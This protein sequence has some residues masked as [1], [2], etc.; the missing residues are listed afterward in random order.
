L[1]GNGHTEA[2]CRI[3]TKDEASSR[4]DTKDKSQQWKNVKIEKN[5]AFSSASKSKPDKE[6]KQDFIIV[7]WNHS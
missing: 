3:K 2:V 4:K 1:W 7:L 6:E 5:Q